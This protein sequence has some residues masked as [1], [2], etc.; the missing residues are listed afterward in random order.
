MKE[1]HSI[2]QKELIGIVSAKPQNFAWFLGA[3]ASRSAGLPRPARRLTVPWMLSVPD[4]AGPVLMHADNR[5]VDHLHRGIM[6]S[7]QSIHDPGPDTCPTR[8]SSIRYA[9]PPG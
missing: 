7:S 6:G 4:D 5:C 3:G 2:D 9:E 8:S 1:Q